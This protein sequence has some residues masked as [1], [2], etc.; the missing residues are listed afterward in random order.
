MCIFIFMFIEPILTKH[1]VKNDHEYDSSRFATFKE[2]KKLFKCESVC[3]ILK[4]GFPGYYSKDL[5]NIY[6]DR[7]TLHYVYLGS[8]GSGKSV[9]AVIPTCSFIATAKEEHRS[10]CSISMG[11]Y[12]R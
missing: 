1:K 6:F 3:N 7:E 2:I 5:N 11:I 9:T 10:N 8:T 12:K 4:P